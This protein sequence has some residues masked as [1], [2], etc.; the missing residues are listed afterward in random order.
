MKK[1]QAFTAAGNTA[2]YRY[3]TASVIIKLQ[4]YWLKFTSST[5]LKLCKHTQSAPDKPWGWDTD[6][7]ELELLRMLRVGAYLSFNSVRALENAFKEGSGCRM[8]CEQSAASQ[9]TE[10]T[11]PSPSETLDC[12]PRF[13]LLPGLFAMCYRQVWLELSWNSTKESISAHMHSI[14]NQGTHSL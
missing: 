6:V 14:I 13:N 7:Q 8:R 3:P 2:F 10:V 1:N 12:Y 5:P 11:W 9:V 4:W